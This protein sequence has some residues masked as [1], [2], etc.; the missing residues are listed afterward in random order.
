MTI[1]T[2][3]WLLVGLACLAPWPARAPAQGG[4]WEGYR[5]A[6]IEAFRRLLELRN[7]SR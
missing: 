7:R 1:H 4:Q 5:D 6:G 2:A 3:K